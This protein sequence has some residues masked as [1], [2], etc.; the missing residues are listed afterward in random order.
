MLESKYLMNAVSGGPKNVDYTEVVNYLTNE[1]RELCC[2]DE[3]VNPI[4]NPEDSSHFLLE[5]S[6]FLRELQCPFHNLTQGHVTDR[7]STEY[8]KLLLLDYLVSEL[9][10]ARMVEINKPDQKMELKIVSFIIYHSI[11]T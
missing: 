9:M 8:D 1:L 4:K 2:I 7:L 5:L 6:S 10:A 11:M 3:C